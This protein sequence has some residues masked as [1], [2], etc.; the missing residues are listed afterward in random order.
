MFD[1]QAGE[2]YKITLIMVAVAGALAGIFFC[3]L[4]MPSGTEAQPRKRPLPRHAM[5]PDVTGFRSPPGSGAGGHAGGMPGGM[6][7]PTHPNG[8]PILVVDPMQANNLI[9]QF[10]P[11]AWD[12]S[13]ATAAT[14]QAQALQFMTPECARAYRANVWT[15]AIAAQ[16]QQSGIVSSFNP[17]KIDV[18]G[19]Q[20]DGT[21]V[22]TVGGVQTLNVPNKGAKER[23]VKVEYL[24]KQFPE[25][26]KIAGIQEVR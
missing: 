1:Y 23:H 9:N 6:E 25:G 17:Q 21:I 10:L 26:L 18:G 3:M 19:L 14:S 12:L 24:M 8:Q 5:D 7:Q 20:A 4:L 11:M 15:D 2:K 13:A 22:I 16:V